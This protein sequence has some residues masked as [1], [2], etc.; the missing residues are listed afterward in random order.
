MIDFTDFLQKKN[1]RVLFASLKPCVS[2][3]G[4]NYKIFVSLS[5]LVFDENCVKS[6]YTNSC[7]HEIFRYNNTV[8]SAKITELYSHSN[9]AKIS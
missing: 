8:H 4:G 5:N 3:Q 7:F 1:V 6:N 2:L 9:L